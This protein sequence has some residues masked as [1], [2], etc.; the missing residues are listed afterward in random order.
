MGNTQ[1]FIK[2]DAEIQRAREAFRA[3]PESKRLKDNLD[4]LI[5]AREAMLDELAKQFG[6]GPN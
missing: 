2:I 1:Q 5:K 3:N 6:R 4:E